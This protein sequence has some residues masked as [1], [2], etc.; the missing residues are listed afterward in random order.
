MRASCIPRVYSHAASAHLPQFP[1]ACVDAPTYSTSS[2]TPASGSVMTACFARPSAGECSRRKI[3]PNQ[4]RPRC[5]ALLR[6]AAP[7][8]VLAL[9]AECR[10]YANRAAQSTSGASPPQ[11]LLA[12]AGRTRAA[13]PCF[14]GSVTRHPLKALRRVRRAYPYEVHMG[15]GGPSHPEGRVRLRL[16]REIQQPSRR[17]PTSRAR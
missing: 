5:C 17:G 15:G 1:T 9:S 7:A 8:R 14:T 13:R 4:T 2:A 16:P 6:A 10:S 11:L 12:R 3:P